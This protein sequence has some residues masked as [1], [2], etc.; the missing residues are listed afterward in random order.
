MNIFKLSLLSILFIVGCSGGGSSIPIDENIIRFEENI[1]INNLNPDR[2]F[3]NASFKLEEEKTYNIFQSSKDKGYTLAFAEINLKDYVTTQ[4]IPDDTKD[5]IVKHLKE[6][7]DLGVK[8]ILRIIYRDSSDG[9]DPS[10]DIALSHLD[11]LKPILQ[12]HKEIISVIQAGVIGAWG[13]WHSFTGDFEESDPDYIQNRK[14]ILEKLLEIFPDKYIQIRYPMEKELLYG[15]YKEYGDTT[16]KAEITKEIAY[17]QDMKAKL[18]HHNDCL[19]SSSTDYGTYESADI[20]FWKSYVENDS[21]FSPVGGET[22]MENQEFTNCATSLIELKRLNYS[23]LNDVYKEE[24]IQGWKDNGCYDEIKNNLG[25][26]LVA[27]TLAIDHNEDNLN[28]DLVI[29][30]KGF[31]APYIDSNLTF[32]LK[33]TNNTYKFPQENID[34]R[35]FYPNEINSIKKSIVLKDVKDGDYCLYL[36]IGT[37]YSSIKLSNSNLWDTNTSSNKL[38]CGIIIK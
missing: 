23:F 12:E 7:E 27:S 22:C 26:R 25:Y 17:T 11:Q 32:I 19:L 38:T 29:T 5:T 9:D 30:N 13:E 33:D 1:A 20:D 35:T 2:G 16:S 34:L 31:S 10:L 18:G 3:Y 4:T 21:R 6:A 15:D 8:L 28:L 36:S 24:V 14:K 37:S